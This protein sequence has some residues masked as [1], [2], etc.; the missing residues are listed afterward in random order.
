MMISYADGHFLASEHAS[1][2]IAADTGGSIRGYRIFTSSVI[3]NGQM[4]FASQHCQRLIDGAKTLNMAT[5]I[6]LKTL[7]DILNQTIQKNADFTV[8]LG[9]KLILTGGISVGHTHSDNA[10]LYISVTPITL[11]PQSDYI[12]GVSLATF[13]YQRDIAATKLT[14]YIGTI[15]AEPTVQ[16]YNAKFPLFISPTTQACLEGDTFNIFFV[17]N[18]TLFTPMADGR[19]LNGITRQAIIRLASP[20]YTTVETD[21]F[22][23]Q[24]STY[25]EAFITSSIRKVMPVITINATQIGKGKPGPVT[26]ALSN[27]LSAE[28]GF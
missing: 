20:D 19:I 23:S 3:V 28:V 18:N 17:K 22:P 2:P 27:K 11:P 24:F 6:T 12:H 9:I 14:Y 10:K 5:S 13:P 15:L 25:D 21:S 16:K 1:I 4:P 8:P 7:L 26:Q